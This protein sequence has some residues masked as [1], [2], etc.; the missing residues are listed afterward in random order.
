MKGYLI[1]VDIGTQGTKA[2]L[3]DER[4]RVLTTSF[5]ASSL[6]GSRSGEIW[7]DADDL[8]G[9]CVRTIR[10]LVEKSGISPSMIEGIGVD[11]QMAGIMGIDKDGEASTCYDSWLDSRCRKYI[12]EMEKQ[13]GE[14]ILK[15][16]GGPVT[17]A[18][19]PKIVWWSREHPDIYK[20]TA[21][22]VLPHGYVTGKMA[23]NSADKAVFDHTCLH[24]NGFSDNRNKCWNIEMLRSF[25][26]DAGKMPRI[27]SPF[28][29]IGK[30]TE[31]FAKAAGVVSG[32]PIAAGLGD[33]A[34]STFG[35]G[36]FEK[37]KIL[38]CAGTAA[39]LCGVVDRYE[40]DTPNRTL[41][42]MRSPLEDIWL[43]LSYIAGG[44]M[45]IRW[46][47]DSVAEAGS[48]AQ[49]EKEAGMVPPGCEGLMFNPHFSGRVLP[50]EPEM[51][52]AFINLD[53]RHTRAH[54][55]RAVF[56]S[57]ACE[58]A[59]YFNI[60]KERF[61]EDEFLSISTVGGGAKSALL[62]QI[63]ADTLAVPVETFE[64]GETALTGSAAV[65]GIAAGLLKDY[66]KVILESMTRKDVY[67]P[68][69]P[70]SG[71]YQE[72]ISRHQEMLALLKNWKGEG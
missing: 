38:D 51:K 37:G 72:K 44:G 49:L 30:T 50:P 57:I 14:E 15:C 45:C 65:A 3:T 40:P 43:P 6:K 67:L 53:F 61:P 62:N 71:I 33:T 10:E 68:D 42:M 35:S 16:S 58:Y 17:C 52:G 41:I 60:L 9:S 19:A 20:R 11:S 31:E 27:V 21:K 46:M 12:P 48:Y 7:Q 47:R 13:A 26:I 2:A 28:E 22:F 34:A 59:V 1:G 54:M 18:H 69:P 70:K 24:F 4:L 36:M 25:G 56:E 5:E 29:V 39:I 64:T 8:Y 32:I 66:R 23:G 63:K 55:Y